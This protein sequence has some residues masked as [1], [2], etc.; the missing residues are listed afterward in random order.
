MA[1]IIPSD[2]HVVGDPAH[3]TD[4]NNI[5]D[6]LR[7][8]TAVAGQQY[9]TNVST[10]LTASD[11]VNIAAVQSA[12]A[13]IADKPWQFMPEAY[14]A[15]GDGRIITD[16]TMLTT[17]NL[18]NSAAQA[19][20]TAADVGKSVLVSCAGGGTYSPLGSTTASACTITA[21]N[22]A[23][24][25]VLSKSSTS[26]TPGASIAVIGTDDSAAFL[27]CIA[28][29]SAFA[30]SRQHG[31]AEIVGS[32]KL[33][34]L[35]G[36]YNPVN[37]L[38]G[39]GNSLLPLP[40]VPVT[41]EKVILVFTGPTKTQDQALIYWFQTVPQA[42]L[43]QI[44]CM[45]TD[46]TNNG[47][48]GPASVCG[49][50]F[51]GY[52]GGLDVG[53]PG[54][55]YSNIMPVVDGFQILVPYNSSYGGW[56]F[57]G[58]A[59]AIVPN[60]SCMPLALVNYAGTG[61]AP[62]PNMYLNASGN[63]SNQYTSGLRLPCT[64]NNDRTDVLSWSC[65]GLCYG[66]MPSEH[67]YV[68]TTRNVYCIIGIEF[69]SG[70][71]GNMAHSALIDY[72]SVES[73]GA[74]GAI[75]FFD[76]PTCMDVQ[77][78]DT[79]SISP[80]VYDPSNRGQGTVGLRC[81]PTAQYFTA[82]NI[83]TGASFTKIVSLD[84]AQLHGVISAATTG[85]PAVPVTTVAQPN[86]FYRDCTVYITSTT[87]ISNVKVGGVTVNGLTTAGAGTVAIPVPAGLTYAVTTTG[88]ITM[89]WVAT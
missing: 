79:E 80:V 66:I 83:Q 63:I 24:Q 40:I 18:L 33:Y 85:Y 25:A 22:S 54:N 13:A 64:G 39:L 75:G 57:F 88:T 51:D 23:T 35:A 6:M 76:S 36:T 68:A 20:F 71:A 29:A 2:T 30:Q 31:Y 81:N 60:G 8:L 21:V 89:Q 15:K 7:L 32:N 1:Q 72:A 34:C 43:S 5:T 59:E 56:D 28:A 3:T 27:A 65:E 19:Q 42:A 26:A 44:V 87:A 11:A 84:N 37:Y 41:A 16:A 12:L 61:G 49:G 58:C 67:S 52:G 73:V 47:T 4:H 48:Y 53:N 74:G 14:G 82:S 9:A 50:P 77:V 10:A 55:P 78:V 46:G 45:R 86:S 38:S 70:P 62:Y 17:S 69:Y